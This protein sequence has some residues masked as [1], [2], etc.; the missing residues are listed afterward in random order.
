MLSV[1]IHYLMGV[2][3]GGYKIVVEFAGKSKSTK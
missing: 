3:Q 1:D 2:K